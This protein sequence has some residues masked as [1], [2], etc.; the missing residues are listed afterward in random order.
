MDLLKS[1]IG[2]CPVCGQKHFTIL[3]QYSD[4]PVFVNVLLSSAD[5]A[6]SCPRASQCIVQCDHCG[7]VFNFDFESQ[8]VQYDA[9]YHA[10]R[11]NSAYYQR[12]ISHVL[13]FIESAKPF[14]GQYVLEVACGGGEFLTEVN[15]RGP[16]AAIGV[17]P[18]TAEFKKGSFCLK[19]LLFDETYLSQ[20]SC[21]ADILIC[22]HMIEHILNPLDMLSKFRRALAADGILYLETP[23][24]NWILENR[25]FFD[26]PYEHCAYYSDH[27]ME[28][29]LKMVGFEITAIEH[30]Y[31]EQYFSI[32]A[33]K[34][35]IKPISTIAERE[36]LYHVQQSC[37][38]LTQTYM[39]ANRS[40]VIQRFCTE[41]LRSGKP[42]LNPLFSSDGV[43]L[44]G[45][46]AKGVMCANLLGN[47]SISGFIDK[48]SNKWGKYIPGTG[49]LVLA[50]SQIAYPI[51]RTIIVENDVYYT[52][53]QDEIQKIDPRILTILLSELLRM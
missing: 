46:A 22:R 34:C 1:C 36:D 14:K 29:L 24:L 25:A 35:E 51:V 49:H 45:A 26:F 2:V 28:H 52:E 18:S 5:E 17:D 44:W 10:E 37:S 9:G 48:N 30:S 7:F 8:K 4:I 31:D 19:K 39:N 42:D 23:R 6:K 3:L 53:I 43:Y 27:F 38:R 20:M 13:D 16:K 15:Q 11:G 50:P 47:W 12:H 21:P 41:T 40:E 32:C 33:K